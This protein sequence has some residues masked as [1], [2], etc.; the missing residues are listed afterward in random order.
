MIE[1]ELLQEELVY[2]RKENKQLKNT[3]ANLKRSKSHLRR[4]N[5]KLEEQ[6]KDYLNLK[7][8]YFYILEERCV[9]CVFNNLCE[10]KE[11]E[12]KKIINGE[13]IK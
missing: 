3:I 7:R 4:Y 2:L 8:S 11:E 5:R 6:N 13:V 12:L 10:H 9:K 1:K